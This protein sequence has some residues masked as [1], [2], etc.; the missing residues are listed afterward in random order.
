MVHLARCHYR[1]DLH[2]ITLARVAQP[3]DAGFVLVAQ[4]Q[5]QRQVNV[6]HQPKLAQRLLG[7]RERSGRRTGQRVGG[8]RGHARHCPSDREAPSFPEIAAASSKSHENGMYPASQG[9]Y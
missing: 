9:H 5:V 7:R 8:A 2:H 3:H 1:L 4:R 6:A